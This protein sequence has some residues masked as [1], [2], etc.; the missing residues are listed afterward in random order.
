MSLVYRHFCDDCGRDSVEPI[1]VCEWCG[2]HDITHAVAYGQV[3]YDDAS[4]AARM[5]EIRAENALRYAAMDFMVDQIVDA[6]KIEL[7]EYSENFLSRK[8]AGGVS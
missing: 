4:D 6:G 1:E 7:P 8:Q 3:D 5:D 2:S